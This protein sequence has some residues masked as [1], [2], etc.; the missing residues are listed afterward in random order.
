MLV[1]FGARVTGCDKK[2]ELGE[3][4]NELGNLGVKLVLGENYMEGVLD[5]S[6]IFRTPSLRPDN[7]Y[8][9]RAK[10]NGAYIT[11]EMIEFLKYC[12]AKI[13]GITGSD[14]KTTTTSLV[15]KML[16]VEGKKVYLGG[17]IGTPLFDM[18]EEIS[19]EDYVAVE[20]S[21][22]QLM[23]C[24]V[25]PDVSVITNLSPNHLDIHRG[26]DEYVESKKNI[27]LHQKSN[28]IVVLNM[29]NEITNNISKEVKNTIR[30]F[31]RKTTD[32]F[33]Y[34]KGEE[35][36]IKGSMVCNMNDIRIPGMHNVEN[37]LA[38]FCTVYDEVSIE[39]MREVAT[40]FAGV[41]HRIEFVR[42]INGVKIYNDAMGTSPTRTINNL[43]HF[44]QNVI[45]IAGGYDKN[46]PFDELARE[47][48]DSLKSLVLIGATKD[49]IKVAFE[50]EMKLRH[51]ELPIIIADTLEE[52]VY[53][54]LSI[55]RTGDVITMSPA[56][57][58]F[59]MFPNFAEKGKRFKEIVMNY[60][61]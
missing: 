32:A 44:I 58:A 52:A 21:S 16:E 11:S 4:A 30:M 28:G 47:G 45:L 12:P 33:A 56:C 38:A 29:D 57:A 8:L 6:V 50:T 2:E 51:E 48:F 22:F 14:G 55:S 3:I 5:V 18:I 17:N 7:E 1:G 60:R 46:I 61:V 53:K 49:K 43:K 13:L 26:M 9:L 42:E 23:D 40:T 27:Y 19:P 25:S 15:A 31:S 39:S 34:L 41:E 20:L 10:A 54:S 35:L 37:L 24:Y 36:Y 59:D